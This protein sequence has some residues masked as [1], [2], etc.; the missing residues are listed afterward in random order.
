MLGVLDIVVLGVLLISAAL[1]AWR[2]F[3]VEVMSLL[4][5]V[6]AFWISFRF[7]PSLAPWFA[8][9]ID[10]P[11]VQLAAGHVLSFVGVLLIAGLCTWLLSRLVKGTGLSGTDRTLGFG[12]GLARGIALC[13][14]GTLLAGFTPMTEQPW[15]RDSSVVPPLETAAGWMRTQLP[16]SLAAASRFARDVESVVPLPVP[17]PPSDLPEE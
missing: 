9:W 10:A 3:I 8:R 12:F 15:W 16:E 5:W 4:S 2:G 6:L 7:G 13:A 11:L 1:G 17:P 14:L